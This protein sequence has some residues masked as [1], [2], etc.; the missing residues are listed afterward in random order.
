MRRLVGAL[1]LLAGCTSTNAYVP[2]P[3]TTVCEPIYSGQVRPREPAYNRSPISPAQA[4][5]A[6]PSHSPAYDPL[7]PPPQPSEPMTSRFSQWARSG[8]GWVWGAARR[9]PIR[10]EGLDRMMV[11]TLTSSRPQQSRDPGA[12]PATVIPETWIYPSQAPASGRPRSPETTP[13]GF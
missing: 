2:G 3:P 13:A 4:T 6:E 10:D 5:V 1:V 11:D 7:L 12:T 9:G 8:R